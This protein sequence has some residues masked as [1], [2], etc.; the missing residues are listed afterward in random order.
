[1]AIEIYNPFA[2]LAVEDE[3]ELDF[4]D[5]VEQQIEA[6]WARELFDYSF[7]PLEAF[8]YE[9]HDQDDYYDDDDEI[10][11]NDYLDWLEQNRAD[12]YEYNFRYVGEDYNPY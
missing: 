7:G 12:Q 4:E 11:Y 8:E 6:P 5:D 1:M 10:Q 9:Y 2:V 3:P